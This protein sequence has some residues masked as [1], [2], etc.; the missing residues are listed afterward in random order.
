MLYITNI[1]PL[2]LGSV[3]RNDLCLGTVQLIIDGD[4]NTIVTIYLDSK[5]QLVNIAG[6]QHIL[7]F[8]QGLKMLLI[9]GHPF[10]TEFGG[11][12]M[13]VYVNQVKHYL[14][15]TALPGGVNLNS[16]KLWNMEESQNMN[17]TSI[18][19]S[20]SSS[21][22]NSSQSD[23]V[24]HN[25]STVHSL[26]NPPS[27]GL[28]NDNSQE[29][30]SVAAQNNAAFDRLLNM[31]PTTPTN[32]GGGL[33]MPNPTNSES[34][35]E[36]GEA[37]NCSYTSTPVIDKVRPV[38][39]DKEKKQNP[40]DDSENKSSASSEKT[41]DVHN[42]WAQLLGAGLVS[43]TSTTNS[44]AIPGLDTPSVD[45]PKVEKQFLPKKELLESEKSS[46]LPEKKDKHDNGSNKDL[47]NEKDKKSQLVKDIVLKSHHSSIKM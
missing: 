15:L 26:Q 3:P 11:M 30:S 17:S 19:V 35:V 45:N 23:A 39:T 14:R 7:K 37:Q 20:K 28:L 16:V 4:I 22:Q 5:P 2:L 46:K 44:F 32:L 10:R 6:K 47:N 41:V 36:Q 38:W 42:L 12:P 21:P 18:P 8:V 1:L 27:P 33:K 25:E 34:S 9:N 29:A 40:T 43:S 31:I 13:V 24:S